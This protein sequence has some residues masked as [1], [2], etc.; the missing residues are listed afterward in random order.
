MSRHESFMRMALV[1]AERALAEKE[2]PVACV[3]V[4][5]PTQ[6]VLSV[7]RNATNASLNGTLHAEFVGIQAILESQ[8]LQRDRRDDNDHDDG[9]D[10]ASDIFKETLLYVTVEPCV[11]CASALRQ[12]KI[13]KV[14]FG[15]GNDRFGGC[16]SVFSMHS[17]ALATRDPGYPV[18]AGIFRKEAIML[19]RR[20]YLLENESAPKPALKSTRVLKEDIADL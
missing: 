5:A 20:F 3:F 19:L 1:E 18:H 17:D 11:M 4:H 2:V 8:R 7:G 16:G 15:C 9:D 14:Y 6:R 13:Q 10:C 12:L